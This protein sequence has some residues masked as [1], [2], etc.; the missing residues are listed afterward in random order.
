MLYHIC[1]IAFSPLCSLSLCS[2]G[3]FHS[4]QN[5]KPGN[6][7]YP[8]PDP[9]RLKTQFRYLFPLEDV[10]LIYDSILMVMAEKPVGEF[11]PLADHF[12]KVRQFIRSIGWIDLLHH[13]AGSAVGE[14]T[15]YRPVDP[16]QVCQ[17]FLVL[18]QA[19]HLLLP[20][21]HAFDPEHGPHPAHQPILALEVRSGG[22]KDSIL[23]IMGG[24]T[25]HCEP[26][27][28]A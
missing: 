19:G 11:T 16:F 13:T 21:A 10:F 3:V 15:V 8:F 24:R 22:I 25:A 9:L 1:K 4:V 28:A 14:N 7:G 2:F 6:A 26:G 27:E 23:N 18:L 12:K 5:K 17:G 20:P